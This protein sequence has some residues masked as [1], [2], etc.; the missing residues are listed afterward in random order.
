MATLGD[1]LR[2]NKL[3]YQPYVGQAGSEA[4][5]SQHFN[6]MSQVVQFDDDANKVASAEASVIFAGPPVWGQAPSGKTFAE[7]LYPIG[8]VQGFAVNGQPQLIPY[9]EV[10]SRNKRMARGVTN[11][12][13][14]LGRV[15]SFHDNLMHALYQWVSDLAGTG[16]YEMLFRPGNK[17][18]R[19]QFHWKNL[20]SEIFAVPFGLLEVKLTAGGDI[21]S[22][23]YLEKCY[24]QN[25]GDSI[26][27][28]QTIIVE[29]ASIF[30][31]RVVAADDYN[32]INFAADKLSSFNFQDIYS[33]PAGFNESL[34]DTPSG[35]GVGAT[36]TNPA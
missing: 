30:V 10:G 36:S 6:H 29:N 16:D 5:G 9:P 22:A 19:G 21:M 26:N 13:A 18:G 11:Y 2:T 20:D 31:T 24:V 32:V 35:T 33:L 15:L 25:E 28:G 12:S 23:R 34:Y 14:Q 17:K 3:L 27:A 8:A 4:N 1:F 7:L